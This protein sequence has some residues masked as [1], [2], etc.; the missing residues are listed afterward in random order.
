[1]F[2]IILNYNMEKFHCTLWKNSNEKNK[3]ELVNSP[4]AYAGGEFTKHPSRYNLAS[5][6]EEKFA[7]TSQIHTFLLQTCL[8]YT[9]E[10]RHPSRFC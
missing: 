4:P 9:T 10:T 8:S 5:H 3:L 1:M 6:R 2:R 7:N